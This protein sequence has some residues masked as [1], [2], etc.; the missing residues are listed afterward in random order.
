[1]H[2]FQCLV[3]SSTKTNQGTV[4]KQNVP[5]TFDV[6]ICEF[7]ALSGKKRNKFPPISEKPP[8]DDYCGFPAA[9]RGSQEVSGFTHSQSRDWQSKIQT[10]RNS[11]EFCNSNNA[12][13]YL[14]LLA[15]SPAVLFL[16]AIMMRRQ[17]RLTA[18]N[19]PRAVKRKNLRN[20]CA[21]LPVM[22]PILEKWRRKNW[23]SLQSSSD[24]YATLLETSYSVR[25]A[26]MT[27]DSSLE[28][29]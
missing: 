2:R 12:L 3:R 7:Q 15:G 24:C 8:K 6:S 14:K 26:E 9:N 20:I 11:V 28:F 13:E 4:Q 29:R 10:K 27:P 19:M 16:Y 1:M 22:L 18:R 5:D 23:R 17:T 21:S 25:Q